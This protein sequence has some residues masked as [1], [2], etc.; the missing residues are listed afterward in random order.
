MA[1]VPYTSSRQAARELVHPREYEDEAIYRAY[2]FGPFRVFRKDRPLG[3]ETPRRKKALTILKW[4][5]LNPGKPSS[6][7][8]FIDMFWPDSPPQKALSNFHVTIH[9]LR[10]MLEPDLDPRQ[11]SAFIRRSLNNFYYFQ[12]RESW[13]T[14]TSDVEMLFERGYASDAQGA[15]GTACFYYRRVSSYCIQ[16][17]LAEDD[18]GDWLLPYRRRYQHIYTQ[19]LMRLMQL[20]MQNNEREELLEYAYQMIQIDPY[21]EL[22][23]RVIIDAHLQS[24][25]VARAERRLQLFWDSLQRDLGV[26]PTKEFYALR[27]RIQ[28]ASSV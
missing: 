5:L 23:T 28:A 12:L 14:D 4:F 8:E 2:L 10:R 24:G 6:A 3:E 27:E 25:N 21:N 26:H 19:V 7:D 16:G 17:F 22:A 11:E 20:S 18:S 9:C 13:W 1:N 15:R